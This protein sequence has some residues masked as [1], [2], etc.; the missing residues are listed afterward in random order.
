MIS[1][2]TVA[3]WS[4]YHDDGTATESA[5]SILNLPDANDYYFC[6]CDIRDVI[7]GKTEG[8]KVIYCDC[9]EPDSACSPPKEISERRNDLHL[10]LSRRKDVL[11][12]CKGSIMFP[13]GNSWLEK[14]NHHLLWEDK[15][16]SISFTSTSKFS[17][18]RDGYQM[19]HLVV[20]NLSM[21]KSVSSLPFYYYG[22]SRLPLMQD[23]FDYTIAEHRD[24]MF[25]H[26]FHL[27]VENTRCDNYF[28]EKLVDCFISKT[29]PI[30]FGTEDISDF[31]N[32][33]GMILIRKPEDLLDTLSNLT[34]EDYD[35]MKTP[36]EENYSEARKYC[37]ENGVLERMGRVLKS[38]EEKS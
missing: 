35:R 8:K 20:R 14:E 26:M 21:I 37:W 28:T 23:T 19:R 4:F 29:V 38:E 22:S 3:S 5:S 31:F 11:S 16:P 24:P 36:I 12:N 7:E 13:F 2:N 27:A 34:P 32:I 1:T 9:M 15:K 25:E 10:V 30:Y 6:F 33:D 18:G 17:P